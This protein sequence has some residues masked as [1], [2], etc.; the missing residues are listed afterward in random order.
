[1]LMGQKII[2]K[3]NLMWGEGLYN[4]FCASYAHFFM[5]NINQNKEEK[6]R[7]IAGMV[8]K[9]ALGIAIFSKQTRLLSYADKELTNS[10]A[11]LA[12]KL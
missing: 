9:Q 11:K 7:N 2:K 6:Q 10:Q 1:M 3:D 8:I 12:D 4:T 5:S